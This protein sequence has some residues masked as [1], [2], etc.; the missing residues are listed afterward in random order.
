MIDSVQN[1]SRYFYCNVASPGTLHESKQYEM[2]LNDA[3]CNKLPSVTSVKP[4]DL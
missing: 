3:D 2:F 4:A 1:S